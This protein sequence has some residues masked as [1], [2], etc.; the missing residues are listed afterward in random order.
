MCYVPSNETIQ[1][2]N[3]IYYA[4][5]NCNLDWE[6]SEQLFKTKNIDVHK[7]NYAYLAKQAETNES[8]FQNTLKIILQSL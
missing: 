7:V 1:T 3:L 2:T 6:T 5:P 4:K 8:Q